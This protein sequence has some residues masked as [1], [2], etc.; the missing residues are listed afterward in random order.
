MLCSCELGLFVR[1]ADD[2]EE[3]DP[4]LLDTDFDTPDGQGKNDATDT[5]KDTE[6]SVDT[7]DTED[8][9]STES[10]TEESTEKDTEK[11]TAVS[12]VPLASIK[13]EKEEVVLKVGEWCA[14]SI[15]FAPENA[16]DKSFVCSTSDN[17]IASIDAEGNV[18]AMGKGECTVYLT[19]VSDPSVKASVKV[20][21]EAKEEETQKETEDTDTEGSGNTGIQAEGVTQVDGITYVGGVM[22]V[23]KTYALPE[24]YNPG[25][26]ATAYAALL[27]MFSAAQSEGLSLW[28]KSGFRSYNDQ[29][30]Q[31]NYYAERDGAALADT[32]SARAG[33]SEHQSGLAFDLNSLDKSFGTTAEG[34]WLAANCHKYGFII[35]Y[36]E[37]KEH[38][39]GYMYE[40]W[41]VRYLGV[42]LA[43]SVKES[44]LCLEE[45]FGITST[46]AE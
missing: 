17:R 22:I 13:V 39:T 33:H 25:A 12:T 42:D 38:L 3:R 40:P 43:T 45:Y 1:D 44:G 34:I 41:H 37:G 15:A 20:T 31:Y 8:T 36:P 7:K 14:Q 27:N 46:Y 23:N 2:G 29:K 6:G 26:D 4:V 18:Y 24:T 9:Q 32:Y 19:S 28:L 10:N 16:T 11:D 21:V 30:W 35:R 5:T